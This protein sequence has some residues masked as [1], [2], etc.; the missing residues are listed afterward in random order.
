[1]D[2][3]QELFNTG[4]NWQNCNNNSGDEQNCNIRNI[5]RC[6]SADSTTPPPQLQILDDKEDRKTANS[7]RGLFI[8]YQNIKPSF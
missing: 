8:K 6:S 2:Q 4:D 3:F 5:D 1:M 7:I